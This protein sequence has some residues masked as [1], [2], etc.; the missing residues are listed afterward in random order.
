[1][2]LATA[3]ALTLVSAG[4]AQA[5]P[6]GS[7]GHSYPKVATYPLTKGAKAGQA[8]GTVTLYYSGTAHR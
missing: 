4:P 2:T 1:M 5:L 3:A 6:Q 7:C 8:Y